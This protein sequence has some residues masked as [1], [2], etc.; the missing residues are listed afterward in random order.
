MVDDDPVFDA[1]KYRD[2]NIDAGARKQV[3]LPGLRVIT[4]CLLVDQ[5]IETRHE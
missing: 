1:Q 5:I 3:F 4:L 2:L